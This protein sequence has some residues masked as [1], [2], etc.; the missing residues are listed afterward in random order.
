MVKGTEPKGTRARKK[1]KAS[2]APK[3][4]DPEASSLTDLLDRKAKGESVPARAATRGRNQATIVRYIRI[5][6]APARSATGLPF[7]FITIQITHTT[8]KTRSSAVFRAQ[9]DRVEQG[10]PADRK[11]GR[12]RHI[13]EA[14]LQRID[15]KVKAG[16]KGNMLPYR[17]QMITWIDEESKKRTHRALRV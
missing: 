8:C 7:H 14:A 16:N 5:L 4:S 1:P 11:Q 9:Q 10:G 2:Q 6:T 12:S 3:S 15:L 13:S 17:S